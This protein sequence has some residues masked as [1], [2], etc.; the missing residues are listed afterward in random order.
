MARASRRISGNS[1]PAGAALLFL[2]GGAAHGTRES[3]D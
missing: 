1:L 2:S 3:D